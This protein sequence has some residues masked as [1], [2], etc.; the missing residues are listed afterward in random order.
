MKLRRFLKTIL[1]PLPDPERE[2]DKFFSASL[3]HLLYDQIKELIRFM[4]DEVR[5]SRDFGFYIENKHVE[6]EEM[7]FLATIN[8]LGGVTRMRKSL[9]HEEAQRLITETMWKHF[10]EEVRYYFDRSKECGETVRNAYNCHLGSVR[11]RLLHEIYNVPN[12]QLYT[13]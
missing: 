8:A 3:R 10:E 11:D 1:H 12:K 2:A 5:R 6:K 13:A 4:I 7:F 9:P